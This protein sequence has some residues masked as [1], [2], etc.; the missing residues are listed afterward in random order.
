MTS[1]QETRVDQVGAQTYSA[2][3]SALDKYFDSMRA[4]IDAAFDSLFEKICLVYKEAQL[5]NSSINSDT[6]NA[7]SPPTPPPPPSP[8]IFGDT[9]FKKYPPPP[10]PPHPNKVTIKISQPTPPSNSE[11]SASFGLNSILKCEKSRVLASPMSHNTTDLK[12]VPPDFTLSSKSPGKMSWNIFMANGENY[13]IKDTIYNFGRNNLENSSKKVL[14]EF[15][16]FSKSPGK[17]SWNI[18]VAKNGENYIIEDTSES[19]EKKSWNI[20]MAK[21]A[22][23]YISRDTKYNFN[24][25]YPENTEDHMSKNNN[26]TVKNAENHISKDKTCKLTESGLKQKYILSS[27]RW[28]PPKLG[29]TET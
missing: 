9:F 5:K 11:G 23:N 24:R 1:F 29:K 14:L 7:K 6:F 19:S 27:L 18:F 16:L 22:E 17:K 13:I 2:L 25:N 21:N 3:D 28:P 20:F 15:T 12:E 26:S 4:H 10:P 8:P